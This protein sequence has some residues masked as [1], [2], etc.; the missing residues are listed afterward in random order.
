MKS[1]P[2][3]LAARPTG[4]ACRSISWLVAISFSALSLVGIANAQCTRCP[5][6]NS[7]IVL[8]TFAGS[9]DASLPIGSLLDAAGTL[10]CTTAQGGSSTSCSGHGCGTVFKV[11]SAG[12]ET[13]LYSFGGPP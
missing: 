13:L 5:G 7:L 2:R 1:I 12:N 11:D 9:H 6:S 10:Y 3:T 4:K 8:H